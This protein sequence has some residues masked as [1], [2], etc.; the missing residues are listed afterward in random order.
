MTEPERP[1]FFHWLG[2]ALG[3]S[4]IL[5]LLWAACG[6]AVETFAS[7]IVVCYL[8]E[9]LPILRGLRR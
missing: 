1:S 7:V 4:L 5:A 8:L 3:K 2:R 9:D 6:G